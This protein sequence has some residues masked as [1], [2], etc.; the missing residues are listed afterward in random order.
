M[1]CCNQLQWFIFIELWLFPSIVSHLGHISR[2]IHEL[3]IF[4]LL[5][6][7]SEEL[8]SKHHND[9]RFQT[10]KTYQA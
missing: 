5:R 7:L 3:K 6:F 10:N 1:I 2:K 9:N 4:L 8:I